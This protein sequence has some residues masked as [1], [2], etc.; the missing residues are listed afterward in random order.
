MPQRRHYSGRLLTTFSTL[1]RFYTAEAVR[2]GVLHV[3]LCLLQFSWHRRIRYKLYA[4]FPNFLCA[5]FIRNIISNSNFFN[6]FGIPFPFLGLRK[7]DLRNTRAY[8]LHY[9][10]VS[11]VA[12]VKPAIFQNLHLGAVFGN[13]ET[14]ACLNMKYI[15]LILIS[16]PLE[17]V[18]NQCNTL[19]QLYPHTMRVMTNCC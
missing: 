11:P 5:S 17:M 3:C 13:D 2:L 15:P 14:Y 7:N 19:H 10:V 8:T 18:P 16:S 6:H 9:R 4:L 1:L 12:Y